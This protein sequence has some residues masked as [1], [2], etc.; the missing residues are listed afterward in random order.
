MRIA[1]PPGL[2]RRLKL[3]DTEQIAAFDYFR[4]K[5]LTDH[6]YRRIWH[7]ANEGKCSKL[8][9]L[10]QQLKG[11]RKG[12]SDVVVSHP[13]DPFHGAYIELKTGN[14]QPSKDQIAWL[15]DM[16]NAGYFCAVVWGADQLMSTVDGYLLLDRKKPG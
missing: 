12:V 10:I 16:R 15:D 14:E 13:V 5:A 1:L 3:E 9:G 2:L 4:A 6:R 11:K 7:P 8:Y